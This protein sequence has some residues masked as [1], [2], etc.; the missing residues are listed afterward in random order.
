MARALLPVRTTSAHWIAHPAFAEAVGHFLEREED[1]IANY[2]EDL[3][4]RNPFRTI[5]AKPG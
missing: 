2:L 1:G 5:S 3:A 4:A